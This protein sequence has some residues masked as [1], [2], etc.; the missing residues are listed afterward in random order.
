MPIHAC[1]LYPYFCFDIFDAFLHFCFYLCLY[2]QFQFVF[3]VCVCAVLLRLPFMFPPSVCFTCIYPSPTTNCGCGGCGNNRGGHTNT[4]VVPCPTPPA[5]VNS[6]APPS[7]YGWQW[8]WHGRRGE[9]RN[10]YRLWRRQPWQRWWRS[11]KL[12]ASLPLFSK[13]RYIWI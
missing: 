7:R 13:W 3:G 10:G 1:W 12:A 11:V 4:G 6:I 9:Q 2:F 5:C 8:R